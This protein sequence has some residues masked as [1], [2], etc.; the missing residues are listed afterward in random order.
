MANIIIKKQDLTYLKWSHTRT[1][2]GTAGT[3][4]KSESR[5]LTSGKKTYYKLSGFDREKGVI[6]HEC[7]NEIIVD[8]LLTLLGVEHLEYSLIHADIMHEGK[9]FDTWICSSEDFKQSGESKVPLDDY[10]VVNKEKDESPY[11]FCIRMGWQ[12]YIEQ[13]IAIDFLIL[14][15]DRHGANIEILRNKRNKTLRI[16]PLFDHGVSLLYSCLSDEAIERFDITEDKP[17]QNFIGSRSTF[18]NLMFIKDKK[19]VFENK[20]T[21]S[22]KEY[23]FKD[24]DNILSNEH[25]DKI[26]NMIWERWCMY[27][28]FFNS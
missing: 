19:N 15:R 8:R 17:C 11:D 12:K 1:S 25:M 14:N 26:W 28:N 27:E 5:S 4:L 21:I 23:L 22:D 20:L 13:M 2:S 10:Y 3:F 16:A 18:S 7:I 9:T 6:G 24:I